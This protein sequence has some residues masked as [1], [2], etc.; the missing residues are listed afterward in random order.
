[1]PSGVHQWWS[2][3]SHLGRHLL[4]SVVLTLVVLA[5]AL[6]PHASARART[7]WTTQDVTTFIAQGASEF[8]VS[9]PYML[10]VAQC[11][12]G[13]QPW[14]TNASTGAAGLYQ[15]M[16]PTFAYYVRQLWWPA[17]TWLSPYNPYVAARLAAY[18]FH[19]GL[20]RLWVCSS[21]MGVL[22]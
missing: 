12:S 1:V 4:L 16:W 5:A 7:S 18:M 9:Y 3:V 22:R 17:G 2:Q 21:A 13:L 20:S 11:E 8:G 10:A 15:F 6:P 19:I 14:V